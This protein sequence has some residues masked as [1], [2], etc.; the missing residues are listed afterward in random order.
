MHGP[1]PALA[2]AAALAAAGCGDSGNS[3]DMSLGVDLAVTGNTCAD[4]CGAITANCPSS[5]LDGGVSAAQYASPATCMSICTTQAGWPPGNVTDTSGNTRGCRIHY[6][7]MSTGNV[8]LHCPH[9]GPS[10]GNG[11]G[12]WC[13][14]YCY[15]ARRNCTGSNQLFPDDAACMTACAKYN[16]GGSPNATAGDTVQCRI[17]HLINAGADAAAATLSCPHAG[18]AGGGVGFCTGAPR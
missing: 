2:C 16:T 15:L 11:C 12:T 7:S 17:Y 4:Y 1:I 8:M 10:G 9:A 14:N 3:M 6:A 18:P 13:E 5:S